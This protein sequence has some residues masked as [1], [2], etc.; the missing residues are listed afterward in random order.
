MKKGK[1]YLIG[2]Y[3]ALG[4]LIYCA[5][6][7][8]FMWYL[9]HSSIPQVEVFGAIFM[10]LLLTFSVAVCG[11]IVFG[12]SVY[13]AINQKFKEA[14]S[15]LMFTLLYCLGFLALILFFIAYLN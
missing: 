10:L 9:G 15:L 14:I 6:V 3:Q 7:G 1:L 11:L 13:L 4:L 12:Y 2:L 5:L 8:S